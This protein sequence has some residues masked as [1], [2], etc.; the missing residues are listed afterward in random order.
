MELILSL[1]DKFSPVPGFIMIFVIFRW[2]LTSIIIFIF[3]GGILLINDDSSKFSVIPG[4]FFV[5]ASTGW[6]AWWFYDRH[7]RRK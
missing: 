1:L 4:W 2:L 3:V 6:A 7:K 5:T